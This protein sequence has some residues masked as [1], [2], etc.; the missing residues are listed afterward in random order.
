M[1]ADK[2]LEQTIDD[3]FNPDVLKLIELDSEYREIDDHRRIRIFYNYDSKTFVLQFISPIPSI[4]NFTL[5]EKKFCNLILLFRDKIKQEFEKCSI[6][7]GSKDAFTLTN[8]SLLEN[9]FYEY[10]EGIRS[11]YDPFQYNL[12]S[13]INVVLADKN[14]SNINVEFE[15]PIQLKYD[16]YC[17]LDIGIISE[18]INDITDNFV[19]IL[20]TNNWINEKYKNNISIQ[21]ENFLYYENRVKIKFTFAFK[22]NINKFREFL[23]EKRNEIE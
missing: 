6:P 4:D 16:E 18:K 2:L 7:F 20:L 1:E 3:I 14:F 8:L 21:S 19:K 12:K 23:K 9:E 11:S 13:K 15:I 10:F 5:Y 17:T 22:L